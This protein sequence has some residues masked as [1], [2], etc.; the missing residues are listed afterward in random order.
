MKSDE[1]LMVRS[2]GLRD[3]VELERERL[4]Q[5]MGLELTLS[6][7]AASLIRQELAA[8]QH[9]ANSAKP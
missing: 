6:Q 3:A 2:P 5:H 1:R 8:A 9:G 7:T 4:R